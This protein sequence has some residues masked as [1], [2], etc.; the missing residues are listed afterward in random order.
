M[1][2]YI[3][4]F[5]VVDQEE[6]TT[7][8]TSESGSGNG[9]SG[10]NFEADENEAPSP[11]TDI[12]D[13]MGQGNNGESSEA[14]EGNEIVVRN[15]VTQGDSSGEDGSSRSLDDKNGGDGGNSTIIAV[16]I[17]LIVI[18]GLVIGY[19]MYRKNAKKGASG[20]ELDEK[21]NTLIPTVEIKKEADKD[22]EAANEDQQVK[23]DSEV[24]QESA[25]I[26]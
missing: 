20:T 10:R 21:R 25:P 16:I 23:G 24:T 15:A 22:L 1:K 14:T 6:D 19:L 3:T 2:I 18:V 12:G 7:Q 8:R 11:D 13:G 5:I 26:Q 9:E 17:V 4:F